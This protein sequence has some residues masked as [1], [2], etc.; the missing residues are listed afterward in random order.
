MRIVQFGLRI[1]A[2]HALRAACARVKRATGEA[3]AFD[4]IGSTIV[5]AKNA[6]NATMLVIDLEHFRI[7]DTVPLI[8]DIS[9][10]NPFAR[11]IIVGTTLVQPKD[12]ALLFQLGQLPITQLLDD[13]AASSQEVWQT[14][15]EDAVG[16]RALRS[17]D[18][19][20]RLLIP[21]DGR[22]RMVLNMAQHAQAASVKELVCRM[23]AA[24]ALTVDSKRHRLWVECN[25]VGLRSPEDILSALRL[26][27]LKSLLDHAQWS[28][29]RVAGYMGF[30]CVRNMTRSCRSR[31]GMS[32]T[33][34]ETLHSGVVQLSVGD[35][36]WDGT[37]VRLSTIPA[38]N[39]N[40]GG[41]M[42]N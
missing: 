17:Y 18:N 36:F 41:P 19:S 8:R 24:Q 5:G 15:V 22:G 38:P 29:K 6:A 30:D 21:P 16:L 32:M 11:V 12:Q 31:Y 3:V 4:L 33:S 37:S 39:F 27:L 9:V 13:Q 35:V 1:G 26:L 25:R 28:N 14:I 23:Y 7:S 20:I 10:L 34:L 42:Y 2:M 40:I